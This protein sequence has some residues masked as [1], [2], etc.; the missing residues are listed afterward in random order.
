M[1]ATGARFRGGS[2]WEGRDGTAKVTLDAG[3]G[4]RHADREGGTK[5]G[6]EGWSRHGSKWR[7]VWWA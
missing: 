6:K 5:C 7:L 1:P 4:Y 3:V 2:C